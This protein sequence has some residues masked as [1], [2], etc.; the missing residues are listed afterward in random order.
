[1]KERMKQASKKAVLKT[2]DEGNP[3][4]DKSW[5]KVLGAI[6]LV[7]GVILILAAQVSQALADMGF[8]ESGFTAF[9]NG[10][11][12]IGVGALFYTGEVMGLADR[13]KNLMPGGGG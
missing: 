12:S 2:D 3:T 1:M 9:K 6:A 7:F 5:F 10:V 13:F 4:E 11:K 8:I